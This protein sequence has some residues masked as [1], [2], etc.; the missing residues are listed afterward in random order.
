LL[1]ALYLGQKHLLGAS[2]EE[3]KDIQ[4]FT[5]VDIQYF[6]DIQYFRW[7]SVAILV[8][9]SYATT[10]SVSRPRSK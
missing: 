2:E 6:T 7:M 3:C 9:V 8:L 5:A 1:V 10:A 4:Y